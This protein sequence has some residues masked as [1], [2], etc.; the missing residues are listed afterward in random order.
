[1]SA[2][3]LAVRV[4]LGAV[5]ALMSPLAVSAQSV[6]ASAASTGFTFKPGGYFK[7]DAIFDR[8]PIGSIEVW[9]PRQIPVDGSEGQSFKLTAR[10]TRLWVD[11]RGPA[12]GREL[13]MY[14]ETDFLDGTGYGLRVR[15]LYGTWGPLLAGQT[16]STFM[17]E[18]I[19]PRLINIEPPPSFPFQRIAMVRL[20][21]AMG[22]GGTWSLAMEDPVH[23]MDIPA[24]LAGHEEHPIPDLTGR[25]RWKGANWHAQ[26]TAL[27]GM[28]RFRPDSGSTQQQSLWGL[29]VA[30]KTILGR[31]DAISA[32]LTTGS[33]VARLH[34]GTVAAFDQDGTLG[35]VDAFGAM[36]AFDHDWSERFTS[37]AVYGWAKVDLA[38]LRTGDPTHFGTYASVN[39]LW[40]FAPQHAWFGGEYLFGSREVQ[41][42]AD[43]QAN[44]LQ[45]ALKFMLS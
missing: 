40:W 1:M 11:V 33:G 17:D 38:G 20:T 29:A 3:T 28:A 24:T 26:V 31:S 22:R 21:G 42:G 35:S 13:R 14:L 2:L 10:D 41:S 12:A 30:G 37:T 45:L 19:L 39:L 5:L 36:A 25:V 32:M 23:K 44:R 7:T 6:A 18:L 34:G 4:G 15:H 27:G 8:D 9:D 43:G 16:W